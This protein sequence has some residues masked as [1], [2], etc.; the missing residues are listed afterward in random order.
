LADVQTVEVELVDVGGELLLVGL[1]V[2]EL[3][4]GE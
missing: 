3:L 1:E 4:G 2:G